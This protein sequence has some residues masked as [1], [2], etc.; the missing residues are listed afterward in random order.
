MCLV[1]V[2]PKAPCYR[3]YLCV[4]NSGFFRILFFLDVEIQGY[5]H[6]L[7]QI[8]NTKTKQTPYFDFFLQTSDTNKVRGI[9]YELQ[10]RKNL[11]QPFQKKSPVKITGTK[12]MATTSFSTTKEE[13]KITK[14]S[15]IMPTAAQFSYNSHVTSSMLTINEALE[16]DEY[17][18]V[19]VTGKIMHKKD[20][21]QLVF[22]NNK[23][24]RKLDCLIADQTASIK[25]TL[26]EDAE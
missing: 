5:L 23:Q 2:K 24:L 20:Q 25:V 15:K 10:Q 19:D 18:T 21:I 14:K 4:R 12:R 7:S 22:K 16:A 13:F 26:W 6:S 17:K 8:K 11:L 3:A 1:V 9:C